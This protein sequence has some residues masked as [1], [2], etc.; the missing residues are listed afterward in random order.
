[1]KFIKHG[2]LFDPTKGMVDNGYAEYAQSPQ[3][4]VFDDYVRVYFSTRRKDEVGQYL[5]EIA[6][7]DFDESF[8]IINYS[9]HQV[10]SLGKLGTYDE[11]GI[12]PIHPFKAEDKLYALLSGWNRRI[13]VPVDTGIGLAESIDNGDT[14]QRLGD[15][16]ILAQSLDEPFLVGDGFIIE[17]NKEFYMYYIAGNKW[18]DESG[19]EPVNRVYKIKYAISTNLIDWEKKN[20]AIITD[21]LNE[22]ECQALPTVIKHNGLYHMIFCFREALDFRSNPKNGYRLGYATSKDLIYWERKDEQ[23]NLRLD[24]EKDEWDSMMLCYPHLFEFNEKIYLLYNGNDFGKHGFGLAE[25]E[26]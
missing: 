13:S 26:N 24:I 2:K 18:I 23:L 5:S 7:I 6:Y 4:L 16:P 12:F 14:F 22:D 3:T 10:I 17:D 9:A 25:L 19:S 11:H 1:M 15:G 8:N 21:V 20:T